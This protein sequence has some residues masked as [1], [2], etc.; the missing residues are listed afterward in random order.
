MH[1]RKRI[2]RLI[3]AVALLALP[4]S[5]HQSAQ[6]EPAPAPA[7]SPAPD[8]AAGIPLEN[9]AVTT[10]Q[11]ASGLKRPTTIATP[12]DGSGR[13]FITEKAGTVRVY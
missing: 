2:S 12:D 4:A 1:R 11:V 10:T 6:A 5:L 9:L 13:L 3:L 7:A 8:G